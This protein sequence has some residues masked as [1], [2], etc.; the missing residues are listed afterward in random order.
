MLDDAAY[1]F[2]ENENLG[3]LTVGDTTSLSHT[4]TNV[5][6]DLFATVTGDLNPA[7][8]DPA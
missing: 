7:H 3:E 8:V 5:T 2:I 1:E 6:F 4:V